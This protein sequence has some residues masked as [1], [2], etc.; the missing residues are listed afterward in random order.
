MRFVKGRTDHRM[1]V[2][3]APRTR[4]GL[5]LLD[6]GKLPMLAALRAI[7]GFTVTKLYKIIQARIISGELLEK[8]LNGRAAEHRYLLSMGRY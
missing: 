8:V 5:F 4:I 6:P 2:M 3:T 1:N 7:N